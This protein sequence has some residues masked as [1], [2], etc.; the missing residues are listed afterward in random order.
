MR[1]AGLCT[2]VTFSTLLAV[3]NAA[4][5]S[6][7]DAA[8]FISKTMD[9]LEDLSSTFITCPLQCGAY[10]GA[11]PSCIVSNVLAASLDEIAACLCEKVSKDFDECADIR[12]TCDKYMIDWES[13]A[14]SDSDDSQA[15]ATVTLSEAVTTTISDE[16]TTVLSTSTYS[17]T[18]TYA[19]PTNGRG[20]AGVTTIVY[21]SLLSKASVLDDK[22]YS[23]YQQ[24]LASI[25]LAGSSVPTT[26]L[27]GATQ[28]PTGTTHAGVSSGASAAATDAAQAQPSQESSSSPAT[29]SGNG[30]VAALLAV[31]AALAA[32]G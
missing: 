19:P 15:S 7:G 2:L 10:I 31:G 3:A 29:R 24:A 28:A 32:L 17:P 18:T 5:D 12:D 13:Q 14:D 25:S 9:Q 4:D 1:L 22:L 27:A 6:G 23:A 30:I 26:A 11:V 8:A 16:S 21:S 20:I